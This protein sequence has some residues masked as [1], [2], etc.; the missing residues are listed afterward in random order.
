MSENRTVRKM[1]RIK[2]FRI[3]VVLLLGAPILIVVACFLWFLI[4]L[5]I[6]P[7]SPIDSSTVNGVLTAIA[8]VF[9]FVS[10]EAREI[11]EPRIKIFFISALTVFLL[12]TTESYFIVVMTSGQAN[13]AVLFIAMCNLVFNIFCS[14]VVI[15]AREVFDEEEDKPQKDRNLKSAQQQKTTRGSRMS[16]D[17]KGERNEGQDQSF[18][19]HLYDVALEMYRYI[20]TD[21][22]RGQQYYTTLNVAIITLGFGFVEAVL[23]L[24]PLPKDAFWLVSP[25]FMIGLVTSLL[26]LQTLTKLRKGFLET[27]WFK[28]VVEESLRC[29]LDTVRDKAQACNRCLLTPTYPIEEKDR[30]QILSCPDI[31]VKS[32][33]WRPW[34]ITFCFMVLQC[35]F[36]VFNV[37]GIIV[38]VYYGH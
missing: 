2:Q 38:V 4:A 30:P 8:I 17:N 15:W 37:V 34:G 20:H 35:V 1:D 24:Q 26:G 23:K 29:E 11:K 25:I 21:V 33:T 12:A 6:S 28:I 16:K 22:W 13:K 18:Q 9:G 3:V 31:W 10:Y 32:T 27:M 19:R 36:F 7:I 14:L 5:N